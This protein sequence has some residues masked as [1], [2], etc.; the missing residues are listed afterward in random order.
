[1]DSS[2][3]SSIIKWQ[4]YHWVKIMSYQHER[5]YHVTQTK[6]TIFLVDGILVGAI[7]QN[8]PSHK[9]AVASFSWGK[10]L[11]LLMWTGKLEMQSP[12]RILLP[13]WFWSKLREP[14][15]VWGVTEFMHW[16]FI[17]LNFGEVIARP[18]FYL[19][20]PKK[21]NHLLN[22]SVVRRCN[23]VHTCLIHRKCSFS[24]KQWSLLNV[25]YIYFS[26]KTISK[27]LVQREL[28]LMTEVWGYKQEQMGFLHE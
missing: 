21:V 22:S 10:T 7:G 18:I 20:Q 27:L 25:R 19:A 12:A 23:M 1:M 28:R 11:G 15:G 8:G 13:N 4:N 26:N 17:V 2:V 3:C 6:W 9:H 14:L 24:L 16:L 5:I